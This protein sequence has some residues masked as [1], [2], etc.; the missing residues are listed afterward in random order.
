MGGVG[1][2]ATQ[3]CCATGGRKAL[4]S[5]R[6]A[7]LAMTTVTGIDVGRKRVGL[8]T[9]PESWDGVRW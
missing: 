1:S 7:C 9:A 2:P 4:C 8:A 5:I 3:K 6:P